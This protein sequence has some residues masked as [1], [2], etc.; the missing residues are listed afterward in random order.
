MTLEELERRL[1]SLRPL[2]LP[3]RGM[4]RAAVLVPFLAR[5][6]DGSVALV[7][8][9]RA[10]DL[11][12]HAGQVAFPGGRM[13]PEESHP[14][15][16]ALRETEEELGVP[17]SRVRT[18]G[19]LDEMHTITGFHVTPVVGFLEGPVQFRPDPVE[20]ARVFTVPLEALLDASRWEER[21]YHH[22]GS[23]VRIWHF[24]YDDED[25]WGVTG[26]ILRGLV[27]WLWRQDV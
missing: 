9:R 1:R 16:T 23:A 27:E 26:T 20:V 6:E 18:V 21:P 19:R 15:E 4:R 12:V 7:L 2:D 8:T 5:E 3:P 10:Q 11:D 22:H 13:E 25:V 24:P 14:E 17:R